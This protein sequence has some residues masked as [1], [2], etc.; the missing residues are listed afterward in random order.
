MDQYKRQESVEDWRYYRH[1]LNTDTTTAEDLTLKSH[2]SAA[3]IF[4]RNVLSFSLQRTKDQGIGC[5]DTFM[6]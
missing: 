3:E 1:T 2:L 6:M 5:L 4:Q